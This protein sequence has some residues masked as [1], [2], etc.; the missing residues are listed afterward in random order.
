MNKNHC[1]LLSMLAEAEQ[2]NINGILFQ[3]IYF[4]FVKQEHGCTITVSIALISIGISKR[5]Y[6]YIQVVTLAILISHLRCFKI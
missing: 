5:D 3:N 4:Y 2:L 1:Q 6:F